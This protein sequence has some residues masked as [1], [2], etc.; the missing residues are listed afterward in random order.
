MKKYWL[1][2]VLVISMSACNTLATPGATPTP[3]FIFPTLVISTSGTVESLPAEQAGADNQPVSAIVARMASGPFYL[4]GGTREGAWFSPEM[5]I[6]TLADETYQV[7][8]IDGSTDS[9][10]G[11][12]PVF[13]EFCRSYRIDMDSNPSGGPAIGTTGNWDVI[14]RLGQDLPTDNST[15]I[16]ELTGWLTGKGF[17]NPVV[18]ISQILRVDLE[19]DGVD[20]VLISASHFAETTYHSVEPGDYSLVLMRKVVGDSVETVPILA[21]YYYQEVATQFP[22]VYTGVFTADLNGD[23]TLEV[24]VEAERWEGSGLIAFEIDETTV[25]QVSEVLCG[26]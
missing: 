25:Q 14:P 9:T 5:V 4:L 6:S 2:G 7:F 12:E 10:S 15:Y 8:T 20:E 3:A 26:L 23:G 22:L 11:A 24:L 1:L 16:D 21:D 13:E 19:G 18:N 17:Q